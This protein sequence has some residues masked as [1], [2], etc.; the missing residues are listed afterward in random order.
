VDG[1]RIGHIAQVL[2]EPAERLRKRKSRA[3]QRLAAILGVPAARGHGMAR[4][5]MEEP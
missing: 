5:A 2:G 3:L 1:E 4:C